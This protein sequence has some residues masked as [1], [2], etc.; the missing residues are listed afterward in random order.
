LRVGGTGG[1]VAEGSREDNLGVLARFERK[2]VDVGS[3]GIEEVILDYEAQQLK[4][5][6]WIDFG[7]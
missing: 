3:E 5:L 6:C 1:L 2:L 7:F 4:H